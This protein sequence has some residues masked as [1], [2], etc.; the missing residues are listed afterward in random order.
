MAEKTV[1]TREQQAPV[2]AATRDRERYLVPPVDIY[3]TD[4]GLTVVADLPGVGK[5]GLELCVKKG[6]L[7]IQGTP[8]H[9]LTKDPAH[10][11][12]RLMK[13]FREFEL[14]DTI[15]VDHITADLKQGVLTILLPKLEEA[16]PRTI[17]V[18][19]R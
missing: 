18:D 8:A 11:E 3:E 7:T 13:F 10:A 19:F 16:K 4:K 5:D 6:M 1:A 2:P 12:F 15:D 17:P 9:L 14:G